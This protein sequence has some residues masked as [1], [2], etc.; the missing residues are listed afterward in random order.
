MIDVKDK[1]V[2][3]MGL[4]VLGRGINVA[5]YLLDRGAILTITDL[6]SESELSDS[7]RELEPYRSKITY[8]L[9][10]H[11]LEDFNQTD[12]VVK[13]AGVSKNNKFILA[14]HQ[15]GVEVKM[16]ASWAVKNLPKG[17]ITIGV[18]GTK[19]KSTVTHLIHHLLK[20][21][22]KSD[23]LGLSSIFKTITDPD[24]DSNVFLGGNVKG[25][26]TLPILDKIKPQDILILELDS[27]QLQGFHDEKI[28][29]NIAI[30]TNFMEDHLNY[31]KGMPE[32]YFDKSAIYR[33]QTKH[34]YLVLSNS[35][36]EAY[37]TYDTD[38]KISSTTAIVKPNILPKDWKFSQPGEH[39][40]INATLAFQALKFLG[41]SDDII[42]DGLVTF[43]GVVGRLQKVT[44]KAGIS[45][46]ND[47]NA[48]TPVATA[49]SIK[50]LHD[51]YGTKVSLICG[52]V[53]K[54]FNNYDDLI[55]TINKYC[56]QV[57]LFPGGIADAIAN[58]L[59]IP[60]QSANSMSQALDRLI[61]A[62]TKIVLMSP[63]GSSFGLFKN[64]YDRG[65]QF[66]ESI[67][68]F[69]F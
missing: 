16:D 38:F 30:F 45:F 50:A 4:G 7:I 12:V 36:Y 35:S 21:L 67:N 59:Q 65:D 8:I 9:E 15:A 62:D 23:Y 28:S 49:R 26:A 43:P 61:K 44:T 5:K 60:I 1:K 37:R 2:T 29:P 55:E 19:G 24:I 17:V 56:D 47:T 66:V 64:E 32:Y 3:L 11:R 46:Y 57:C 42:K 27:W 10:R 68:K 13:A 58:K 34:D 52:G 20:D 14:A 40:R 33:Y 63:A 22:V 69:K 18:T 31:Y 39:N 41:I 51:K 53:S 48:T 6:K 54:G 25:Q